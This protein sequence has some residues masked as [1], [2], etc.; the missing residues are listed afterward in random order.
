LN[1]LMGS[2]GHWLRELG[3]PQGMP[4]WSDS[5]LL[6]RFVAD[7]GEAAFAA[8][9][10]RHG[11]MVLQVCRGVVPN[12]HDAEDAFQATFLVLVRKAASIR[13]PELL[14]SWL[15]GVAYRVARRARAVAARRHARETE[16]VDMIAAK[17]DREADRRDLEPVVHEE[18]ERLPDKY[19]APLVLCYFQGRTSAEA[20]RLLDWPVGTVKGRMQRGRE[21][22]RGRLQRRG[23]ALSA[24]ALA[25]TATTPFPAAAAVPAKLFQATT[26]AALTVAAGESASA[27]VS[28][29]AAALFRGEMQAMFLTKLK[30]AAGMTVV[31]MAALTTA[32]W[33]CWAPQARGRSDAAYAGTQT[34]RAMMGQAQPNKDEAALYRQSQNNLKQIAL[35]MHVYHDDL[36]T[37]PPAAV[38]NK[39]Q[40][41]LLSWRVL[42]LQYME[43]QK[44]FKE[45]KLDEPWDSDHNKKLLAKMPKIYGPVGDK[46][47]PY[48]TYYQVFHG[49][50]AAFEGTRG[51][52]LLDFED[53]TSNTALVI[54]A[55]EA[56]PWTKP[57]DLPFDL[58]KSLPKLGG[59]FKDRIHV[60]LADGAVLTL[61]QDF[62]E[63]AMQNLIG[64]KDGQVLVLDDL[65]RDK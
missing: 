43:E 64:R 12:P 17:A 48:T 55:G 1:V 63:R 58:K 31:C 52:R 62:K 15:Y 14:S 29:P 8:L 4:A 61:R 51:V 37:F 19:R 50:G 53:G 10:Q 22:L 25:T 36:G 33:V 18:L 21:L 26:R 34:A 13:R 54:E 28:A 30:F 32:L 41:A 44:L 9:L 59:L 49:E 38:V 65:V 7:G 56:V 42:L 35:A 40:K 46:A 11:P 24:L 45:F 27:V 6:A 39:N 60:A 47:K 5:Q 16:G 23:L 2:L 57:A 20:A 3:S